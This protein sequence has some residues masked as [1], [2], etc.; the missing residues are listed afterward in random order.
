MRNYASVPFSD[1]K[2]TGDFWSERLETVL[3]ATIPSQYAQ[4]KKHGMLE[5]LKLP[6]PVPPLHIPPQHA[7]ASP[8]RSSGT[9]TSANGSRPRPTPC[10][11]A[12]TR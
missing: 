1:V 2:I 5:S 10:P 4:L 3:N 11:T 9:A 8:R 7:T 6:Q 12:A